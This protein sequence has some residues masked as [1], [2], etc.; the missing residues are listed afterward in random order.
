MTSS[1]HQR[2]PSFAIRWRVVKSEQ[3]LFTS[4]NPSVYRGFRGIC[5]EWRVKSRAGFF[6]RKPTPPATRK[7][8]P[9]RS[10]SPLEI[11]LPTHYF[12][13]GNGTILSQ[14]RATLCHSQAK[15]GISLLSHLNRAHSLMP[16]A[17]QTERKNWFLKKES[18]GS[19]SVASLAIQR[20]RFIYV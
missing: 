12:M 20:E 13:P 19:N 18:P 15:S 9:N 1:S 14:L 2:W 11:Y 4:H 5:E 7:H 3:A 8:L 17:L 6:S 10:N 16:H